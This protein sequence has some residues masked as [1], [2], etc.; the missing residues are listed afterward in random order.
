M[1]RIVYLVSFTVSSSFLVG[2]GVQVNMLVQP[3]LFYS[4]LEKSDSVKAAS[5]AIYIISKQ[6]GKKTTTIEIC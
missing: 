1:K 3:V 5:V 6:V 2:Q 4:V